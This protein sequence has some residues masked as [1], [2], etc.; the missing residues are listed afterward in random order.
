MKALTI[1]AE[2]EK[3][4]PWMEDGGFLFRALKD[5]NLKIPINRVAAI[6]KTPRIRPQKHTVCV[7]NKSG[8]GAMYV[9]QEY[10]IEGF[11]GSRYSEEDGADMESIEWA[12]SM[13]ALL[14]Y[15]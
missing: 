12:D 14:G 10:W 4:T 7:E 6:E 3:L 13:L 5:K 9:E 11:K 15:W 8:F 2:F 1:G